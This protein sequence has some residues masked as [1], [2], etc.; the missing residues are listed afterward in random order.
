[1]RHSIYL[2]LS[3]IALSASTVAANY[4]TTYPDKTYISNVFNFLHAGN[5]T[6]FL[7]FVSPTVAWTIMGTHPLA[8]TYNNRTL[9]AIDALAR[10]ENTA[11]TADPL[12]TNVVNIVGGGD[13]EW[14][15]EEL[16]IDGTL[17]NGR[18]DSL[19]K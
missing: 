17:K 12:K 13:E 1:M 16:K 18:S 10:L 19:V 5:T 2:P 14:S 15:V 3:A 8:G 6:Q 4:I 9:F 7:S 11:S